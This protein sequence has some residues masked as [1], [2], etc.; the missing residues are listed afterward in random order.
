MEEIEYNMK[1]RKLYSAKLYELY[2]YIKPQIDKR[3]KFKFNISSLILEENQ[4]WEKLQSKINKMNSFNQD[5]GSI[6][7]KDNPFDDSK[8][9]EI[10]HLKSSFKKQIKD[11][12]NHYAMVSKK[13]EKHRIFCLNEIIYEYASY[14]DKQ[15]FLIELSNKIQDCYPNFKSVCN[16]WNSSSIEYAKQTLSSI[17]E[18]EM[19]CQKILQEFEKLNEIE[20]QTNKPL[21]E[22]KINKIAQ[23]CEKISDLLEIFFKKFN[24]VEL[25]NK[26][27]TEDSISFKNE[28]KELFGSNGFGKIRSTIKLVYDIEAAKSRI[29]I[30]Y[31]T[32]KKLQIITQ[33]EMKKL[34][35]KKHK[36]LN[37]CCN[38]SEVNR[39]STEKW[40]IENYSEIFLPM[41][42]VLK[43]YIMFNSNLQ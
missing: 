15:K 8:R 31:Q 3:N 12:Q 22:N 20:F 2:D 38:S 28:F 30:V 41:D 40:V 23:D 10:E 1:L 25:L 6:L 21:K 5:I 27:K 43:K 9:K 39:I 19:F 11:S 35:E 7:S 16:S 13:V 36:L 33:P 14:S 42:L 32:F 17:L 4:V 37:F 26:L 24:I 34:E 29:N 18:I